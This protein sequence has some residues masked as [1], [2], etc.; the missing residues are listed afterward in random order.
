MTGQALRGVLLDMD[1]T[2]VDSNDA[3][4]GAWV[5]ALAEGGHDVPFARVRRLIGMG[6]DTLL[7]EAIG[8]AKDTPQGQ[9]LSERWG[10]IFRERYLPDLQP[11]PG[12]RELV[13][14]MRADGLRVVIASSGEREMLDTLIA[15]V[16]L[17]ALIDGTVSASDAAR[18]KPAPD[19]VRAAL[20]KAGLPPAATVLLGDTPYDIAAARKADVRTIALRCGGFSD[21]DL[22]GALARY[23]DPA[24]LLARFD[25]SPLA[26]ARR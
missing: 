18:S 25:T 26:R 3:H 4:A 6:S 13:A 11:F 23:D 10:A 2:L 15:L 12:A 19:L 7:P 17:A 9:R 1:G 24:D 16:G 22:A 20:G 14:R 5:A 21:A 8:L